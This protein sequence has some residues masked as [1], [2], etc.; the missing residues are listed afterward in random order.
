MLDIWNSVN[1]SEDIEAL[2]AFYGGFHDSCIKELKYV[3]GMKVNDEKIML[4][5]EAKDRHVSIIFQRQW[6]PVTIELYFLG[7][8]RMSI[9]G[10][11][12]NYLNEINNCYLALRNDLIAGMDDDMI[13][14]ADHTGFNPK[15]SFE[16]N[17]LAEPMT[18]FII[19]DK[20][21]W[22]ETQCIS[23]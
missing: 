8:R 20:L 18:S 15:D 7:L 9:A 22:R 21:L 5:G 17:Y 19:A 13:V 2:L 6:D 16:R 4:F 10:W 1:K 11:Q 3:S 12:R 23:G 14:W